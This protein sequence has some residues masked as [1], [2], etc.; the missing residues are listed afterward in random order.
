MALKGTLRDFGISEILQLIGHQHKSGTLA[1]TGPK[2]EVTVLFD[3]GQI[4]DAAV[5][6]SGPEYDLGL[7]LVGAGLLPPSQLETARAQSK[8]TLQPLEVIL[9]KNKAVELEDLRQIKRLR[10]LEILFNLFLWKDGEYEFEAGPVN[11]LAE[12]VIPISSEQV[13]MDGY[14]IKDEWP[15][16]ARQIPDLRVSFHRKPGD[17]SV[18]ERLQPEDDRMYRLIEGRRTVQ[19]LAMLSRQGKF[20]TL[21]TLIRL[22]ELGRIE[23]ADPAGRGGGAGAAGVSPWQRRRE[24]IFYAVLVLFGLLL[25]NGLRLSLVQ[26]GF[27]PNQVPAPESRLALLARSQAER[28]SS[29]IEV[30]RLCYGERPPDLSSLVRAGLCRKSDL[31]FPWRYPYYYARTEEGFILKNPIRSAG[32]IK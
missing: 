1:V 10:H 15:E 25:L 12:L 20:E 29:A 5:K 30:H 13:L 4:V 3:N 23:V 26:S 8:Q 22:Q 19:E 16:V 14:R 7:M 9:V 28:L 17:F 21:K 18:D 31:R 32:E 24:M 11:F 6:P 2:L 27:F